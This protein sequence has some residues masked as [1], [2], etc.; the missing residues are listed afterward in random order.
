VL[1]RCERIFRRQGR[2]VTSST[3]AYGMA[4][5]GL[6][7]DARHEVRLDGGVRPLYDHSEEARAWGPMA[8]LGLRR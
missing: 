1:G 8:M 3:G 6:P 7:L 5:K 4:G 2:I